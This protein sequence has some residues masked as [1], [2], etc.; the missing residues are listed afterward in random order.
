MDEP[1][2]RCS[3]LLKTTVNK[4]SGGVLSLML[5]AVQKD[6]LELSITQAVKW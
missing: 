2:Q 1:G 6:N 5:L 3:E 4:L